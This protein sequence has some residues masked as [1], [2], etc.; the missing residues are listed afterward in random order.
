MNQKNKEMN[1]NKI[2]IS[3]GIGLLGINMLNGEMTAEHT[4]WIGTHLNYQGVPLSTDPHF[5]KKVWK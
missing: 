5:L 1:N 2:I 4:K 3:A